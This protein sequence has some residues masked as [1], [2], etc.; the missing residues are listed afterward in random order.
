MAAD[1][2]VTE[3]TL[4]AGPGEKAPKIRHEVTVTNG[5]AAISIGVR[6][7]RI[8]DEGMVDDTVPPTYVVI[9]GEQADLLA[10]ALIRKSVNLRRGIHDNS[11]GAI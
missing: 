4:L 8:S 1:T 3:R 7:L 11:D 9:D 5:N 10:D 6:T 2:I